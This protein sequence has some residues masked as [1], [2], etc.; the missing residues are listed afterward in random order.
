MNVADFF[1]GM[2]VGFTCFAV[3]SALVSWHVYRHPQLL[4]RYAFRYANRM[5]TGKK[6]A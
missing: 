1:M 4:A 3:P 5:N 2:G 6:V